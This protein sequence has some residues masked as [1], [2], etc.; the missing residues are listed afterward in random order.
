MTLPKKKYVD[1]VTLIDKE[2]RLRPLIVCWED[3][4]YKIDQILSVRQTHSL[5]GGCGICYRCR[6]GEELRS[7]FW[8][9]D[10]WFV[11]TGC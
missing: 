4:K 9:R 7:L 8:E 6:F 2:G 5:A 11:E 10:R 3:H 1:V